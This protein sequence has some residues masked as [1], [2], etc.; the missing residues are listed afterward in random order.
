[1][2][3]LLAGGRE[4]FYAPVAKCGVSRNHSLAGDICDLRRIGIRNEDVLKHSICIE[5]TDVSTES[6]EMS[7]HNIAV[8]DPVERGIS[9]ATTGIIHFGT[10]ATVIQEPVLSV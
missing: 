2:H 8:A 10:G 3:R 6:L 5:K 9:G 7:N 4:G 1:M